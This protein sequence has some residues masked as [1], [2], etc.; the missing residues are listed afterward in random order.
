MCSIARRST[1]VS[2]FGGA[3]HRAGQ[4]YGAHNLAVNS[5]GDLFIA[6]TYEGKRLQKFDVHR[7]RRSFRG[8]LIFS[9]STQRHR[10]T[11]ESFSSRTKESPHPCA[12]ASKFVPRPYATPNTS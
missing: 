8:T 11:E 1:V 4:F 2:T 9:V 3:G 6:E 7:P 5:K 10:D 12:P